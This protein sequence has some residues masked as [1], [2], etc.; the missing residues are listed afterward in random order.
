MFV[1]TYSEEERG[2]ARLGLASQPSAGVFLARGLPGPLEASNGRANR[3]SRTRLFHPFCFMVRPPVDYLPS[4]SA[5]RAGDALGFDFRICRRVSARDG[6]PRRHHLVCQ[7]S[8]ARSW[9]R[10]CSSSRSED[11]CVDR[12]AAYPDLSQRSGSTCRGV[13][14]ERHL[15]WRCC[16]SGVELEREW[17]LAGNDA[18]G[19]MPSPWWCSA[20]PLAR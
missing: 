12:A 5:C 3:A 4:P 19:A 6:G 7:R 14:A 9:S 15:G 20:A 13:A 2:R 8:L 10:G 1:M 11:R 16:W 17:T 18:G